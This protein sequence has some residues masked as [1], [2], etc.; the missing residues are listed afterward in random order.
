MN[1]TCCSGSCNTPLRPPPAWRLRG[2]PLSVFS[3]GY[4]SAY[5][6]PKAGSNPLNSLRVNPV[7]APHFLRLRLSLV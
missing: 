2:L 7:N 1:N 6:R 5:A 4:R 3:A